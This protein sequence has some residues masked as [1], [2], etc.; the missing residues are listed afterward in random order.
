M[1]KN[2]LGSTGPE[3]NPLGLGSR[4]PESNTGSTED[5]SYDAKGSDP[6]VTGEPTK[7]LRR[8]DDASHARS[9]DMNL[10]VGKG[11][12][13]T[14][15]AMQAPAQRDATLNDVTGSFETED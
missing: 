1:S 5:T 10:D 3:H 8:D 7:D 4:G 13:Q 12:R 14:A 6:Y 2:D 9:R 11:D 15:A